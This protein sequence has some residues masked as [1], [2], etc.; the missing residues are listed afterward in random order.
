MSAPQYLLTGFGERAGGSPSRP[1]GAPPLS[2]GAH[3]CQPER[4]AEE[5][6]LTERVR[7][8][9]H[10]QRDVVER[11]MFGSIGFMVGGVLRVGVGRHPDHV[12]M[13]RI[14][15]ARQAQALTEPGVQ[16]AVMR[17]RP[18]RGWLFFEEEAVATDEQLT[19]WIEAALAAEV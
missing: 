11:R 9:L 12:M 13:A 14:S 5:P 15:S 8:A 7:R 19:R 10:D 2:S 18:M 17:G 1:S 4:M 16:P 6:E 3:P